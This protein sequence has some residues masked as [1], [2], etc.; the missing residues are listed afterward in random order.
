MVSGTPHSMI[1][2]AAREA[3]ADLIVLGVS[4]DGSADEPR[5][6]PTVR[7]VLSRARCPVLLVPEP[8]RRV[9]SRLEA[10]NR[11]RDAQPSHALAWSPG[12]AAAS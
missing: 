6:G 12:E 2:R 5:L 8:R 1:L 11:D 3:K 9:E 10:L 4:V 7:A